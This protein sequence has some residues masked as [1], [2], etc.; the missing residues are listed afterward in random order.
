MDAIHNARLNLTATLVNNLA[1]AFA[2]AG[3]VA[4]A[5]SG[6]L[7]SVRTT[8]LALVWFT[9]GL[10]LHLRGRALLRGLRS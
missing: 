10:G 8:V 1:T 4:P 7:V 9:I 6:Q 2:V 3:L 5:A